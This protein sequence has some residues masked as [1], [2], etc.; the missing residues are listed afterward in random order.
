MYQKYL[1]LCTKN[2]VTSYRVSKE[3]GIPQSVLHSWK[4]GR[5]KPKMD[6]IQKLAKYFNVPIE[7][8]LE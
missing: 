2:K 8:F 6:K 4:I 1:E 5:S 3:T 7:H